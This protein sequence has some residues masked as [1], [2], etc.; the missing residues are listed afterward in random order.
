MIPFVSREKTDF[1]LTGRIPAAIEN[2]Q[3]EEKANMQFTAEHSQV[4]ICGNPDMLVGTRKTLKEKG[5]KK[6]LRR[7]PGQITTENYW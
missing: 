1:A 6:N 7:S 2:G 5:L 4:M 3:L